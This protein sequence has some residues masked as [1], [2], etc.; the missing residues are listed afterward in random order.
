MDVKE[1][2]ESSTNEI[3]NGIFKILLN[4]NEVFTKTRTHILFD[5]NTLTNKSIDDIKYLTDKWINI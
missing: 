3:K 2:I 5:Y 4:N 1:V